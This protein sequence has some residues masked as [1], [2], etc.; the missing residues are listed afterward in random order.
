MEK[1]V[2]FNQQMWFL[3]VYLQLQHLGPFQL[4]ET[5]EII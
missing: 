1:S 5:E 3:R 2:F 4:F